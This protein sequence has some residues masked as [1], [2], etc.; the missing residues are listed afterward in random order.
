MNFHD[1]AA[2][3]LQSLKNNFA[4]ERDESVE[5]WIAE[6]KHLCGDYEVV[7]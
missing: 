6:G 7:Y 1:A 3:Y 4:E 2:Y 5:K